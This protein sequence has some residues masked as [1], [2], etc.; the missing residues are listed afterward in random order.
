MHE[1]SE[2]LPDLPQWVLD[3]IEAAEERGYDKG[4]EEARRRMHWDIKAQIE[5][6]L[7]NTDPR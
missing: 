3:L 2:P 4:Q 1:T 7:Q 6:V 5:R